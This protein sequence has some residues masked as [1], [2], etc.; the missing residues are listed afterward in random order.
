MEPVGPAGQR[1]RA[2]EDWAGRGSRAAW[3]RSLGAVSIFANVPDRVHRRQG[4][5]GPGAG[6][7]MMLLKLVFRHA[8]TSRLPPLRA[9]V[10]RLLEASGLYQHKGALQGQAWLHACAR[11]LRAHARPRASRPASAAPS[12]RSTGGQPE[13][14]ARAS[15]PGV[16]EE[17]E[18]DRPPKGAPGGCGACARWVPRARSA[19]AMRLEPPVPPGSSPEGRR[20]SPCRLKSRSSRES[21]RPPAPARSAAALQALLLR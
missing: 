2:W 15:A 17:Q 4:K 5:G 11:Q 8:P 6:W 18:R 3:A 9:V 14:A 7:A 12:P 10:S 13:G 19:P 21:R 16:S 20:A 1:P